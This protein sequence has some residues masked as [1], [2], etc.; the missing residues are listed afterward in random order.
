VT[1]TRTGGLLS[2]YRSATVTP[3]P[4]SVLLLIPRR[5]NHSDRRL[6]DRTVNG[7][8]G[9]RNSAGTAAIRAW[10]LT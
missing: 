10:I 8:I 9:L 2:T 6:N 3:R 7:S 1:S 5:P 4:G